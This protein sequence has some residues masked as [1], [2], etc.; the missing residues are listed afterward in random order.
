MIKKYFPE[1][2]GI[3]LILGSL[4]SPYIFKPVFLILL[5]PIFFEEIHYLIYGKYFNREN[6]GM[7]IVLSFPVFLTITLISFSFFQVILYQKSVPAIIYTL[8]I[9]FI[10]SIFTK[11]LMPYSIKNKPND[12]G[13]LFDLNSLLILIV[14]FVFYFFV[15]YNFTYLSGSNTFLFGDNAS[16][17]TN[18]WAFTEKGQNLTYYGSSLFTLG[19]NFVYFSS[20][21]SSSAWILSIT[22]SSNNPIFFYVAI[23]AFYGSIFSLTIFNTSPS[24]TSLYGKVSLLFLILGG[25]SLVGWLWLFFKSIGLANVLPPFFAGTPFPLSGGYIAY[26]KDSTSLILKGGWQGPGFI[27]FAVFLYVIMDNTHQFGNKIKIL[28]LL[29]TILAYS[30]LGFALLFGYLWFLLLKRFN[31][32]SIGR[33]VILSIIPPAVLRVIAIFIGPVYVRVIGLV[34]FPLPVIDMSGSLVSIALFTGTFLILTNFG[35][36]KIR[37]NNAAQNYVLPISLIVLSSTMLVLFDTSLYPSLVTEDYL[38]GFVIAIA[39]FFILTISPIISME[40]ELKN[41]PNTKNKK[42][43]HQ[44][45]ILSYFKP[46]V[47]KETLALLLVVVVVAP[48]IFYSIEPTYYNYPSDQTIY[49]DSSDLNIANWLRNNVNQNAVVMVPPDD[50]WMSSLTGIQLLVTSQA[51]SFGSERLAAV[52]SF[53]DS[54]QIQYNFSQNYSTIGWHS[55]ANHDGFGVI[56]QNYS[57]SDSKVLEVVRNLYSSYSH[58]EHVQL[59]GFNVSFEVYPLSVNYSRY[60]SAPGISLNLTNG[61]VLALTAGPNASSILGPNDIYYNYHI[62]MVKNQWNKYD[63]NISRIAK[64]LRVKDLNSTFISQINLLGGLSSKVYWKYVSFYSNTLGVSALETLI[65]SNEVQYIIVNN[66][67][68]NYYISIM[69]NRGIIRQVYQTAETEIYKV[70]FVDFLGT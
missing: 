14:S 53:Y 58:A 36:F 48:T 66:A 30:P 27:C 24:R 45:P 47:R 32:M 43:H 68:D 44:Y 3:I 11:N 23:T 1:I 17:L 62:N 10:V 40:D 42:N 16:Y 69:L 65:M 12:C 13:A 34:F 35:F 26:L 54:I 19:S 25:F 37:T 70:R 31:I 50:F 9:T 20:S 59:T 64:I 49:I 56:A 28:Y 67:D 57:I 63:L 5:I 46:F 21:F 61:D 55:T 15:F 33:V 29:S 6:W 2:F 8:I 7:G 41:S 4:V 52:S 18:I 60:V 38:F 39:I 51:A 22:H